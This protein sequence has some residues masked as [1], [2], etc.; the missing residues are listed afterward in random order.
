MT[1]L[2]NITKKEPEL[3]KELRVLVH[4][5]LPYGAPAFRARAKKIFK[6]LDLLKENSETNK[7]EEDN[8]LHEWL[9]KKD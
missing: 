1:V 7:N 9:V 3:L 2:A 4:Q 8:L 5:M 6:D